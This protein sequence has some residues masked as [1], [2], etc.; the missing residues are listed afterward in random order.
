M[1]T[2]GVDIPAVQTIFLARPTASEILLRQMIGRGLRGTKMGGTSTAYLV[3]FE[4][5]WQEFDDWQSPFDLVPDIKNVADSIIVVDSGTEIDVPPPA[6]AIGLVPWDIVKFVASRFSE[7]QKTSL[8]VDFFEAVPV[9]WYSFE[10]EDANG[11]IQRNFI[12]V[13][14]HEVSCWEALIANLSS[15]SATTASNSP[16]ISA[17]LSVLTDKHFDEFFGDCDYPRP[18]KYHV[19]LVVTCLLR[20]GKPEPHRY[21]ERAMFDPF[22]LAKEI[23]SKN[24]REE[25]QAQLIEERYSGLA[26]AVYPNLREFSR[27]IEEYKWEIRRP[28]EPYHDV[29]G[30]PVFFE[31]PKKALREGPA[32]DLT[33][34]MSAVLRDGR[35]CLG[36][37]NRLPH[38]GEVV[39]SR[40]LIKGWCGK[41]YYELSSPNGHGFIRINKLLDSPSIDVETLKFLLWH[42]YL[43]LYLKIGHTRRFRQ[44]EHC[45]VMQTLRK[46]RLVFLT[47]YTARQSNSCLAMK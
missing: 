22:C 38:S 40:R 36:R 10:D 12:P 33:I 29:K 30:S 39:W 3:S 7:L 26:A 18:S 8:S 14:D 5:H 47:S 15:K 46:R 1:L 17:N 24:L 31:L 41:A 16:F 44:L 23:I 19:G 35:K 32:Y 27:A 4:D 25:E 28:R 45:L 6:P 43:H 42:E 9:G 34:L 20:G 37:S 21:E 2:E 11:E 13:Y